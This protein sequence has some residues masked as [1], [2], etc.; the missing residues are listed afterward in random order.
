MCKVWNLVLINDLQ[1]ADLHIPDTFLDFRFSNKNICDKIS[2]E[3]KF[4]FLVRK[5]IICCNFFLQI[6]YFCIIHLKKITHFFC[7]MYTSSCWCQFVQYISL[8]NYWHGRIQPDHFLCFS[9][10]PFLMNPLRDSTHK[11]I[12]SKSY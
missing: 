7:R 6:N 9:E 2:I 10:C 1:I 12:F 5:K 4:I 3:K 8:D 11:E